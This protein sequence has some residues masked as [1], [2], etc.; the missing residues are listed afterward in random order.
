MFNA[1]IEGS[2]CHNTLHTH[3]KIGTSLTSEL[4]KEDF[5]LLIWRT[6]IIKMT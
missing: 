5:E 4:S 2:E 3:N 1:E 6:G